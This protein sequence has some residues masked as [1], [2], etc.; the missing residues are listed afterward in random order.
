MRCYT[1]SEQNLVAFAVPALFTNTNKQNLVLISFMSFNLDEHDHRKYALA[2][3]ETL[4]HELWDR[5]NAASSKGEANFHHKQ[6]LLK[7]HKRI[8]VI[9]IKLTH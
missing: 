3:V 8:Q 1:K 2:F 9:F 5:I 4:L 7:L 6:R